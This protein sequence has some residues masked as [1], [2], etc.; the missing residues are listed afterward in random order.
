M[1]WRWFKRRGLGGGVN[2]SASPKGIGWSW[3]IP[4]FRIGYSPN[5]R[6]WISIGVPGTGLRYFKYLSDNQKDRPSSEQTMLSP[7]DETEY[8][9]ASGKDR[10][11][12]VKR[13]KDL[14]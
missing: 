8:Q 5:G 13:W 6:K 14:K 9:E 11:P 3:G 2:A 1:G 7:E 4:G 12:R 10:R